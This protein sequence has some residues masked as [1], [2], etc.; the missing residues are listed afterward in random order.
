MASQQ[1][2]FRL[3]KTGKHTSTG[4]LAD[5][6]KGFLRCMGH[7]CSRE[8]K[9]EEET[10]PTIRFFRKEQQ[11]TRYHDKSI[12]NHVRC[13]ISVGWFAEAIAQSWVCCAAMVNARNFDAGD[14]ACVVPCYPRRRHHH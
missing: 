12:S 1:Y 11:G 10:A 8:T 5:I 9:Q 13:A 4:T 6:H 7:D 2:V 14:L 3:L